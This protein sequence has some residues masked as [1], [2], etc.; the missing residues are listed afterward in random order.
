MATTAV[1]G[2]SLAVEGYALAGSRVY[3]AD[4]AAEAAT[5][6]DGLPAGTAVV[7]LTAQAAQW[8]GG[9]LDDRPEILT[10]VMLP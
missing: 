8:L 5:A 7:L 10:A 9:R 1:I 6:F 2:E 4:S 3:R